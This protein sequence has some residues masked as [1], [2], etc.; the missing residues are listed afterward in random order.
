MFGPE[1]AV[2]RSR[3]CG[4]ENWIVLE[5]VASV[6]ELW[7][8]ARISISVLWWFYS[9]VQGCGGCGRCV[10]DTLAR[11]LRGLELAWRETLCFCSCGI[12]VEFLR[13]DSAFSEG[14]ICV[15][16]ILFILPRVFALKVAVRIRGSA[17]TRWCMHMWGIGLVFTSL[18]TPGVTFLFW[19]SFV[20]CWGLP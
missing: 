4:C 8:F 6:V 17:Y 16:Y 11:V 1:T 14:L 19:M 9:R 5:F 15:L 10:C 3:G 18:S 12:G 2:K 13:Q 7:D 20:M